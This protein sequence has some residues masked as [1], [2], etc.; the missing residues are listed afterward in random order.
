MPAALSHVA[1]P[2]RRLPYALC[3]LC[4]ASILFA[5][6]GC[7]TSEYERRLGQ[8][9]S[10]AKAESKWNNIYG[11]QDLADTPV[12]VRVPRMFTE[13]PLVENAQINGKPVDN[14]RVKPILFDFPGLKLTYEM[15]VDDPPNGKVPCYCYVGAIAV[16]AGQPRNLSADVLADLQKKGPFDQQPAWADFQGEMPNGQNVPWKK[17]RVTSQQEFYTVNQAGQEQYVQLPGLL[18]IYFHEEAGQQILV[19]WRMPVTIE[20]KTELVKWAP[21]VAGCVSV[22][23]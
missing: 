3:L 10:K 9:V 18:E 2:C 8:A 4:C 6:V 17:L 5:A 22:K 12:S 14:R 11:P 13:P 23:K 15:L 1:S 7:G 20:G 21:V 19:A 16:P